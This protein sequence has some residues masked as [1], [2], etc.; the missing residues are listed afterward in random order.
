MVS[1][2]EARK[3]C[4]ACSVGP[5]RGLRVLS[6]RQEGLSMQS[7][8]SLSTPSV[9]SRARHFR[10]AQNRRER[11]RAGPISGAGHAGDPIGYRCCGADCARTR[12]PCAV[13][14][15][16]PGLAKP[17]AGSVGLAMSAARWLVST[18]LAGL[19]QRA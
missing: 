6:A 5:W 16:Q 17:P 13:V 4:L 9:L 19:S 18:A 14:R 1:S 11:G 8:W 2:P 10:G 15:S 3:A 12:C 7:E